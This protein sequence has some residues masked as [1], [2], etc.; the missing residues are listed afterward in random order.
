ME[1]IQ[2]FQ[3]NGYIVFDCK[4]SDDNTYGCVLHQI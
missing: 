3:K 2:E 1:K 4:Q